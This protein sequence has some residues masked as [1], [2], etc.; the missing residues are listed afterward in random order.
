[1]D[2]I[3]TGIVGLDRMLGGIPAGKCL[4]VTGTA[5]TGKTIM[6]LHLVNQRCSEGKRCSYLAIEEDRHD[7]FRQADQFGWDFGAFER[8]GLLEVVPLLEERM[9]EAKYQFKLHGSDAGFGGLHNM[10]DSTVDTLVIDNLGVLALDMDLS[11]FRQQLD[12]LVYSLEKKGVT[13]LII[14][15]DTLMKD[16][17]EVAY[18]SVHGAI[19]LMKRDNP[20]TD[21]RERALEVVKMRST[22]APIDYILFEIG[23]NGISID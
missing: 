22:P 19:R 6:A 23:R 16:K 7:L 3:S 9:V 21:T 14:S 17:K 20:Y 2:R 5:G 8:E 18:Y 11:G 12:Y 15:D 13:T 10:V 4:L 1:M